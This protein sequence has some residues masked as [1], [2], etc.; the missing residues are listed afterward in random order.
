LR[1]LGTEHE[2]VL[3]LERGVVREVALLRV[4]ADERVSVETPLPAR[5]RGLALVMMNGYIL[6][7]A[8]RTKARRSRATAKRIKPN[9]ASSIPALAIGLN[10]VFTC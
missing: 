6:G 1:V 3:R 2:P 7:D 4:V 10:S 9:R 8:T 5:G